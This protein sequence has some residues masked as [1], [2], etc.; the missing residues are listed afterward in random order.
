ME[1]QISRVQ[2]SARDIYPGERF[3]EY[4]EIIWFIHK[5]MLCLELVDT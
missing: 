1:R 2:T 5:A 3:G 4:L